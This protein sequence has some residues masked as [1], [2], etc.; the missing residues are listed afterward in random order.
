MLQFM[1]SQRV[2]HD[3]ATEQQRTRQEGP[4]PAVLLRPDFALLQLYP[5]FGGSLGQGL[6]PLRACFLPPGPQNSCPRPLL[7]A[8]AWASY[9]QTIF[10]VPSKVRGEDWAWTSHLLQCRMKAEME[11][12][13]RVVRGTGLAHWSWKSAC[14]SKFEAC[15]SDLIKFT[16][17]YVVCGHCIGQG[18][19]ATWY[20]CLFLYSGPGSPPIWVALPMY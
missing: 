12:E 10:R 11:R 18:R 13:E 19:L 3:L 2:R 7:L 1:G 17:L 8:S 6:Y 9:L 16:W 5:P 4:W 14:S 20:G 15:L